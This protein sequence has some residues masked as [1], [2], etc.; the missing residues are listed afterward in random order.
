MNYQIIKHLF[1]KLKASLLIDTFSNMCMLQKDY[2]EGEM[3][4]AIKKAFLAT[5]S[6]KKL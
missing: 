6:W 2:L 4:S 1:N 5:K 3:K